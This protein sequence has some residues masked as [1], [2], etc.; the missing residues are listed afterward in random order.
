[1]GNKPSRPHLG[2]EI[3]KE[4]TKVSEIEPNL[5]LSSRQTAMKP[6]TYRDYN[7]EAVV[8]LT[9]NNINY[10]DGVISKHFH[11]QDSYFNLIHQT[12]TEAIEFI[13][14]MVSQN[15]KVLVHC[16]VG[17]SRSASCVIAYLMK[18]K[19]INFEHAY[20]FVKERR[21]IVSPN[22]GF[23]MQL[24]EYQ[25]KLGIKDSKQ[26]R[27]FVRNLLENTNNLYK[28]IPTYSLWNSFVESGFCYEKAI[29]DRNKLHLV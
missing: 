26:N 19:H 1:M 9:T 13:E 7:I 20:T 12:L 8:S 29:M 24:Y 15:K 4:I 28:E 23:T 10:P 18:T 3:Q 21:Q 5:F 22:P 25:M 17:V 27:L 14:A 6:S 2:D 11:V 16:E